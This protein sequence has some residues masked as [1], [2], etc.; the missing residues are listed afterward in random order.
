MN[1]DDVKNQFRLMP[2]VSEKKFKQGYY[3][4]KIEKIRFAYSPTGDS[5]PLLYGLTQNIKIIDNP[6]GV[7]TP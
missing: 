2:S 3:N 4:Q 5:L 1:Q 6:E 7:F